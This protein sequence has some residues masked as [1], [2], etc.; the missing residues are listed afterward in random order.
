MHDFTVHH[1]I[2]PLEH[3]RESHLRR[4]D[5]DIIVSKPK[6][7][8]PKDKLF[9]SHYR[10]RSQR[11]EGCHG[12][13]S[14]RSHHCTDRRTEYWTGRVNFVSRG[15][16]NVHGGGV[17]MHAQVYILPSVH[18]HKLS[19]P[20]SCESERHSILTAS[21]GRVNICTVNLATF[22][23]PVLLVALMN[24][25]PCVQISEHPRRSGTQGE[26]TGGQRL[27]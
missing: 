20:V 11:G 26:T 21:Y 18:D 1:A 14:K 12:F 4:S 3:F 8:Y 23:P 25:R 9:K 10:T 17:C 5:L 6:S 13:Y 2:A 16:I 15:G 7:Q 27:Q 19:C 22:S 24:E